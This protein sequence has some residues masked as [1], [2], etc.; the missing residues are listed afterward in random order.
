MSSQEMLS[1]SLQVAFS[2]LSGAPHVLE[3]P[4]TCTLGELQGKLCAAFGV[5]FPANMA[6][7]LRQDEDVISDWNECPFTNLEN[8]Q[9]I[10]CV[11]K[12]GVSEN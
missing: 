1:D 12:R 3:V 6:V 10:A 8:G 4:R 11:F 9:E 5:D 7:L 2:N